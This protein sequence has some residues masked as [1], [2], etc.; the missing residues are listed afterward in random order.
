LGR[1]CAVPAQAAGPASRE[2][3][4]RSLADAQAPV[5]RA[6]I[7]RLAEI[8]RMEDAPVLLPRLK[9][10]DSD[11]R[12]AAQLAL[13]A[14]WSRSGDE[15]V[16]ALLAHGTLAMNSGQFDEALADFNRVVR[17]K[18]GFAEGWNKRATL[19]YMVGETRR[20]MADCAEVLKLNPN[21]FGALSGYGQL[22]LRLEEP[23]KALQFF[24]RAYAINPGMS[25]VA[26]NIATLKEALE[27]RRRKM[28]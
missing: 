8:G 19:Y 14:V 23:E 15:R 2:Q 9:D 28:I 11:V 26:A 6:A 21:H 4:L 12:E 13:W 17:Q 24:E 5:R 25:G 7:V 18:P 16:D 27:G 1:A 20:S 10:A 3:A 22:Y